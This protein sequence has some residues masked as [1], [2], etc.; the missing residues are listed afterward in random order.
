MAFVNRYYF[1]RLHDI[2]LNFCAHVNDYFFKMYIFRAN[3]LYIYFE[4]FN[5]K[6][7]AVFI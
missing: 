3:F 2:Y 4:T 7:F 1:F 6:K 5:L